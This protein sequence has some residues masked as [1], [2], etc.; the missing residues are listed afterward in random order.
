MENTHID[1]NISG[2]GFSPKKLQKYTDWSLEIIA[3]TGEKATKGRYKGKPY[4]YG[5]ALL[6][7]QPEEENVIEKW[8]DIL[9]NK[10][11]Y[12]NKCKIQK[13]EFCVLT[14]PEYKDTFAISHLLAGK[15]HKLKANFEIE[16]SEPAKKT[17]PIDQILHF[18]KE[19]KIINIVSLLQFLEKTKISDNEKD[20]Y[21]T[22]LQYVYPS[23][24]V[25]R[26]KGKLV[27]VG[28]KSVRAVPIKQYV[29]VKAAAKKV[30][31]VRKE[32]A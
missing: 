11:D 25:G 30:Y 27:A 12:L 10:K 5:M 7:I 32:K 19:N 2:D 21:K 6:P 8:V 9:L 16:F 3:E 18:I 24:F 4:P 28:A 1:I 26:K 31:T 29:G 13:I 17:E 20:K 22:F 23:G 14:T 15:L